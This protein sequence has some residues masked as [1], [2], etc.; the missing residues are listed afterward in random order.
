MSSVL[1]SVAYSYISGLEKPFSL[2][3]VVVEDGKVM[4]DIHQKFGSKG[5]FFRGIS[6]VIPMI[7]QGEAVE[8]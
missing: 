3:A 7:P 1:K 6:E 5:E 4:L 8:V 2:D